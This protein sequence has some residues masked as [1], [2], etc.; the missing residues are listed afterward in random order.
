MP[1]RQS[2][3]R[4]V[5]A[6]KAVR[7]PKQRRK[8]SQ[9]YNALEIAERDGGDEAQIPRHRLGDISDVS[10]VESQDGS[11]ERSSKR[12]RL[13]SGDAEDAPQR[14]DREGSDSE[15]WHEGVTDGDEDS[16][17]ASDD[18]FGDGDEERFEGF[19]FGGDTANGGKVKSSKR[20]SAHR[21]ENEVDASADSDDFGDEGVDLATA[22]D[23]DN[24]GE[25]KKGTRKRTKSASPTVSDSFEDLADDV[26]DNVTDEDSSEGSID[27]DQASELSVS[28]GED[29][30]GLEKLQDFVDTLQNRDSVNQTA[31]DTERDGK[32]S[33]TKLTAADLLKYVSDPKQ[34]QSLKVL[35]NSEKA[36]PQHYKGGIPGKLEPPLA[37]R[38]QDRLDRQAAYDKSKDT[39][40]RWIDTVKQNRR[41]EHISFPL[42]DP[43]SAGRLDSRQLDPISQSEPMTALESAIQQIL[44]ESGLVSQQGKDT[45]TDEQAF[46]ELQQRT[47][48]L[49]EVVARRAKLRQHR[50]LMFRE[51]IR[52][53]RIKKIKSKAY[54]RV[55]RKERDRAAQEERAQQINDGEF[56]SDD[57]RERNDRQ[58]AEERM[59][60]RHRESKWAKSIKAG[61][62]TWD[63]NARHSANELARKG[64]DLRRRTEGQNKK[65]S[66]DETS[67]GFDDDDD[68]END[69]FNGFEERL[70]ELNSANTPEVTG[71]GAMAFMQK[72]EAARRLANDAEVRNIRHELGL[73]APAEAGDGSEGEGRMSFGKDASTKQPALPRPD[74]SEFEERLSDDDVDQ[75]HPAGSEEPQIASR[76][77][78]QRT[79]SSAPAGK[80]AQP[81]PSLKKAQSAK[82]VKPAAHQ[83][84]AKRQKPS[85]HVP[86]TLLDEVS[87][88][89][90]SALQLL[91]HPS[92]NDTQAVGLFAGDDSLEVEFEKEKQETIEEEGDQVVDNTLPGWG[93]WIGAG[94]SKKQIKR[95][96]KRFVTVVK[97]VSAESRKDAKLDRVIINEK[98][99]KKNGKYLATELPHPF[100]SRHQYERSLR[101]PIGPEWTTKTTF[102]DAVKPRIL[103]KQG[104]IRPIAKP[105]V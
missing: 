55:H 100:E 78:A 54:R 61:R 91:P 45:E 98:Q 83:A 26:I 75:S 74:R 6:S 69:D 58:R 23:M 72:A 2:H 92:E 27:D 39:L 67:S 21:H 28:D 35:I 37:K 63:E 4:P 97:G 33:S 51:E 31:V 73:G 3:G 93:S 66:D 22:W 32:P 64:E 81:E 68:D 99:V 46:E 105:M 16:E 12:R 79:V 48:P 82:Q 87:E 62:A 29:D 18:A 17:I 36:A 10:D 65:D 77:Q 103:M 101:L 53:R 15:P 44:K 90:E 24:D 56:N 11:N 60:A 38:Q 47:M 42:H 20:P 102:Q 89:D 19:K 76:H 59:G 7:E 85:T 30:G 41:A 88:D 13:S 96:Q 57:D 8:R 34:R 80:G 71:L 25:G 5:A 43:A 1:G 84:V 9:V 94:I 86:L 14:A 49:E 52:A 40:N 95:T 70:D 50:E 104:V